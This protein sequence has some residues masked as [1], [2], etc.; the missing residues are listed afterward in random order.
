MGCNEGKFKRFVWSGQFT[1][2][3]R[4]NQEGLLDNAVGSRKG[5]AKLTQGFLN[6]FITF[7][8]QI[9]QN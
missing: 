9:F 8:L 3:S 1:N 5:I 7:F 2:S 6:I 4:K